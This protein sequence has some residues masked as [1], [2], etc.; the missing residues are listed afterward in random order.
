MLKSKM[1]KDEVYTFKLTTGEEMIAKYSKTEDEAIHVVKPLVLAI[2][3]TE[4]GKQAL[5]LAPYAA[6]LDPTVSTPVPINTSTIVTY[7]EPP[8]EM[9]KAY[10]QQTS[11][12]QLI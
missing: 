5:G 6:T 7:F 4:D 11:G 12:I 2:Q 9:A 8:E 3:P 10:L 1:N